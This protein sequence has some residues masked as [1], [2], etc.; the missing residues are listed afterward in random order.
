MVVLY[1]EGGGDTVAQRAPLRRAAGQF[2]ERAFPGASKPRVEAWGG[3][4]RTYEKFCQGVVEEPEAF[5]ILLVDSEDSVTSPSRWEHVHTRVGDGWGPPTGTGEDN[6]HFMAQAME[7]WLCSDPEALSVYFRSGFNATKLPARLNLEDEPK[8]DLTA[9]LGA[10]T[11]G[12]KR[13]EYHKGQHLDILGFIA[14]EK[15]AKRCPGA[16]ALLA[17]LAARL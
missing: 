11:R 12:S 15:V 8:A 1:V 16:A 17:V 4:G 13:G 5:H 14:P 2:I 10:A 3:R 6:L 9:K 7:A